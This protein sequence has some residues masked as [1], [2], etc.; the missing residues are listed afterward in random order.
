MSN[1]NKHVDLVVA[2]PKEGDPIY[3]LF[4]RTHWVDMKANDHIRN[5]W[6]FISENPDAVEPIDSREDAMAR[7]EAD[8]LILEDELTC[9][10]Y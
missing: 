10:I 1:L 2:T 6:G 5:L 4:S 7:I 8:N 3:F 9:E